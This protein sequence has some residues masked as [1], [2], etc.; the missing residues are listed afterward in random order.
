MVLLVRQRLDII[1]PDFSIHLISK[2][3]DHDPLAGLTRFRHS[4]LLQATSELAQWER[5]TIG[6]KIA[7]AMV[8][9][10]GSPTFMIVQSATLVAWFVVNIVSVIRGWDPYA[11]ILLNVLLLFH[12]AYATLN[13]KAELELELLHGKID[14]LREKEVSQTDGSC[15]TPERFPGGPNKCDTAVLRRCVR[16]IRLTL[17]R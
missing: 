16:G 12:A 17:P 6:R 7:K 1:E 15:W 2:R 3:E 14:Q 11:F 10:M 9:V 8:H 13:V 4:L 5:S